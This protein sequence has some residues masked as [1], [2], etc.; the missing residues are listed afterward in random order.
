M[1]A[2][3][4][5]KDIEKK[6]YSIIKSGLDSKSLKKLLKILN[7]EYKKIKFKYRGL[8]ARD[9]NDRIIY[10]LQNKN[11]EFVKILSNKKVVEICKYFLNDD[12]FR[13]IH[14]SKPNYILNYYNARSSGDKLDL[15]I[16]SHIPYKGKKIYMMQ[17]AFILEDQSTKNGCTIVKPKS[18]LSGKYCNRKDKKL[19]KILAKAGDIV[20]WDSRLW[21]G[22]EANISGKSR[23]S[24]I[25]T[26]SSWWIKQSMDI[27]KSLPKKIFDKAN[28]NEK[29]ML[30]YCSIIPKDEQGL[31]RTKRSIKEISYNLKSYYK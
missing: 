14:N 30:G 26:F 12:Y 9:K 17:V 5:I 18:H 19:K 23:W 13:L 15:H 22:T 3:K 20:I 8:P 28:I 25:A 7:L 2:I 31:I 27:T 24:L 6:G 1:I 16:D 10:N 11:Y 21:H 29:I 4:N